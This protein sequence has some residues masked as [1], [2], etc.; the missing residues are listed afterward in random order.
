MANIH[1]LLVKYDSTSPREGSFPIDL[2]CGNPEVNKIITAGIYDMSVNPPEKVSNFT[3]ENTIMLTKIEDCDGGYILVENTLG[4]VESMVI[5]LCDLCVEEI[6]GVGLNCTKPMHVIDCE[7]DTLIQA[8]N[9]QIA[10]LVKIFGAVD[11]LEL[12]TEN[13]RIEAGQ[14]NLNTDQLEQL[15]TDLNALVTL[16]GSD[17]TNALFVKDCGTQDL[18]DKLQEV[19]DAINTTS[20]DEQA[21]LNSIDTKLDELVL[22]KDE[23]VQANTTLDGIKV[24]TALINTNLLEVIAKLDLQ[25]TAL[26]DLKVL[27]TDTNLKLDTANATL[28]T[29]STDVALIKA[30]IAT[31]KADVSEIKTDV[32]SVLTKL[33]S[34]IASLATIE[35]KLDDVIS[36][37]ETINTTLQTEFDQTQNILSE[38]KDSILATQDT[39]Q[40]VDC[41]GTNLGEVETVQK[42]VVLNKLVSSICNSADISNPIVAA[43]EAQSSSLV[44][45]KLHSLM[46]SPSMAIGET[47]TIPSEKFTTISLLA[48]KGEFTVQNLSNDFSSDIS[49]SNGSF[50]AT[51]EISEDGNGTASGATSIPQGFDTRSNA[52]DIDKNGNSYLIT[53]VRAGS[54]VQLDL[55]K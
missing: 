39:F 41:F 25:I 51:I 23:L 16:K 20:A 2:N 40:I 43:I 27:V 47:I 21:I 38:I 1:N 55:Y 46:Q 33:D 37:L 42:T 35:G 6:S 54:I 7:R 48:V 17:C 26:N 14:I 12:T 28:T 13:I 34:V 45:G 49:I 11:G 24:D 5:N 36:G 22:I 15:I 52:N 29:I 30:D 19:I 44:S 8:L 50:L 53:A 3:S 10:E 18:L 31:I 4:Q 9:Q 32:K